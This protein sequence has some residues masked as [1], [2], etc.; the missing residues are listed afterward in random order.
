MSGQIDTGARTFTAAGTIKRFALVQYSSAGTITE[1]GAATGHVGVAT[2]AAESGDIIS[3]WL[4]SKQGTIKCLAHGAI[5]KGSTL[6]AA[7][8]GRVTTHALGTL[9]GRTLDTATAQGDIIE[10]LIA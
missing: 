8:D 4:V 7:A 5:T 1:A 3:V 9:V 6:E 10:V 2:E